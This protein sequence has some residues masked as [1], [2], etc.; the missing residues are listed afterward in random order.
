MSKKSNFWKTLFSKESFP[1]ILGP[2]LVLSFLLVLP[3]LKVGALEIDE[4]LTMRILN[5]SSSRKTVLVNRGME[6]G[7][8]VGD[9]AKFYLTTGIVARG[10]I[11]K[12]SPSRSIWSLYRVIDGE[13]LSLDKVMN[14]KIAQPVKL[15]DDRTKMLSQDSANEPAAIPLAPGAEDGGSMAKSSPDAGI[16]PEDQEDLAKISSGPATSIS[17][18]ETAGLSRTRSLELWS[19]LHFSGLSTSQ[20]NT[21]SGTSSGSNSTLDLSAGLEKYFIDRKLW[22]HNMS[23]MALFHYSNKK[24]LGIG[25]AELS[26]TAMEY[27][28]GANW[29]FWADPFAYGKPI[30]FIGG[31]FGLGSTQ[32]FFAQD[33]GATVVEGETVKGSSSF[34]SLGAGIKYYLAKGWGGRLIVDYYRRAEQYTFEDSETDLSKVVSGPRVQIGLSYRW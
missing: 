1:K 21:S 13:Q 20:D 33:D 28:I 25:G 34:F 14:L 19:T 10:I 3:C 6:D 17:V 26:L 16:T 30:G 23:I 29:H 12:V 32:E 4:K 24:E 8:A 22:L 18:E 2:R 7:L 31:S 15:T 11:Q 27:G 5:I 9:H